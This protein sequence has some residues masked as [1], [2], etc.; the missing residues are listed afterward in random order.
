MIRDATVEDFDFIFSLILKEAANGTFSRTLLIPESTRGLEVE[1]KSVLSHRRRPNGCYAHALIWGRMRVQIGF[2][3]LS[4]LD[5]DN[6]N[7][8][9]LAAVAPRYRGRGEGTR[10]IN[11]ILH[12]FKRQGVG[13]MAR[14]APEAEAMYHIL[15]SSGFVLDATLGTGTRQLA[16]RW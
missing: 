16:T 12:Q 10:M 9:W 11:A 4:A 5:G 3:V 15:T 7:E 2:L 6:G 8:L 14:C 13:L 1:L